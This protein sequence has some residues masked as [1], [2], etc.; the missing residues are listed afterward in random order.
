MDIFC[1]EPGLWGWFNICLLILQLENACI[2]YMMLAIL[3]YQI[4]NSWFSSVKKNS[5]KT[6][7]SRFQFLYHCLSTS[8]R[9]ITWNLLIDCDP[10]VHFLCMSNSI[11]F[12]ILL[13][14][15]LVSSSL[16]NPYD[17][18]FLPFFTWLRSNQCAVHKSV[19]SVY[20][21][22]QAL[23]QLRSKLHTEQNASQP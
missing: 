8:N 6:Y 17:C 20:V 16:T 22:H 7:G 2:V 15:L 12:T 18:A 19:I 13:L 1:E 10:V 23:F 5:Q 9:C 3:L 14:L 11:W 4:Q 21:V